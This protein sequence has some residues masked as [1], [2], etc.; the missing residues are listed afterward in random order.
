MSVQYPAPFLIERW[1]AEFEFLPGM[2]NLAASGPY[3]PTTAEVLTLGGSAATDRYLALGLDYVENPGH[4]DLRAAIA[5][6]HTTLQADDLRITTGASE[7][8]LLLFWSLLEPGDN[9]V[10]ETP[11]YESHEKLAGALGAEVRRL[12]LRPEDGWKPDPGRLARLV[13]GRTRLVVLSH[14]HNPS[15]AAL[16]GDELAALVRVAESG[17][18]TVLSDEVFRPIALDGPPMPSA[19]DLSERAVAVGDLSKPWG[20]AG[21]RIG[22]CATHRRDLLPRL[23]ELRNYTTMCSSAPGEY[24]ATLAVQHSDRLLAPRLENARANRAALAALVERSRGALRWLPPTE[25]YWTFLQLASGAS[26][27]PLCRRLAEERRILLLPGFVFGPAYDAYMRVG[28]GGTG[29]AF[30]HG[31]GAVEEAVL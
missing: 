9:V 28:F 13:D 1:F 11:C 12:E 10:V 2:R 6:L 15:G 17:G 8:I 3:A 27:E 31:L 22:W 20:L 7:A 23:S 5:A 14:P 25:G 29:D 26:T 24:L 4:Q 30:Q 18:A 21:V 16:S 19:V